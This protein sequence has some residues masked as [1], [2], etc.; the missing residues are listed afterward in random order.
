LAKVKY[1]SQPKTYG[2]LEQLLHHEYAQMTR[3]RFSD[4]SSNPWDRLFEM[5]HYGLPTRL[6]DW[7]I[8]L[9]HAL[10]FALQSHKRTTKAR[11]DPVIWILNPRLLAK[12]SL[13]EAALNDFA[14]LELYGSDEEMRAWQPRVSHLPRQPSDRL[15]RILQYLSRHPSRGHFQILP[16]WTNPRLAAQMGCFTLQSGIEAIK[17]P[18]LDKFAWQSQ[19]RGHV[20]FLYKICLRASA[21][22]EAADA[23]SCLGINAYSVF[24]ELHETCSWIKDIRNVTR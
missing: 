14:Y 4:V 15:G 23:L 1:R 13:G 19:S 10:W 17:S 7:S 22:P 8:N 6:L 20:P 24:P 11:H 21:A 5:Q 12:V 2:K 3:G 9:G 18:P 16:S